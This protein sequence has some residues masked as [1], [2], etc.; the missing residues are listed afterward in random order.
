MPK[1]STSPPYLQLNRKPIQLSPCVTLSKDSSLYHSSLMPTRSPT[2]DLLLG[3]DSYPT[4]IG[5][6]THLLTN[7]RSDPTPSD[8]DRGSNTEGNNPSGQT[9][10]SNIQFTQIPMLPNY[11][12]TSLPRYDPAHPSIVPSRKP[13]HNITP[14][15]TCSRYNRP[16]HNASAFPFLL[17]GTHRF[18]NIFKMLAINSLH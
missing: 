7:L 18:S 4:T 11:D 5:G 6:A 16:G 9:C 13:P 3:Q 14:R 10:A 12:Y 17:T 8:R 2:R 1:L 15:I